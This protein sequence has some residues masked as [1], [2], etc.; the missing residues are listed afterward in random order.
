MYCKRVTRDRASRRR[1][2]GG[3]ATDYN[4]NIILLLDTD[5]YIACAVKGLMHMGS[6]TESIGQAVN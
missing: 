3:T 4:K 5:P 6:V 2:P 1:G